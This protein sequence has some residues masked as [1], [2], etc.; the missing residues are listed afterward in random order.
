MEGRRDGGGSLSESRM[1]MPRPPSQNS[2]PRPIHS[3]R[4]FVSGVGLGVK[5]SKED[6]QWRLSPMPTKHDAP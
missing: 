3:S 2:R 6:F 4:R 1:P 5:M